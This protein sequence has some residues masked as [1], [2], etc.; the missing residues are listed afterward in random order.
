MM[1]RETGVQLALLIQPGFACGTLSQ[2]A[3]PVGQPPSNWYTRSSY[4]LHPAQ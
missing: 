2:A 3:E 1:G 4:L